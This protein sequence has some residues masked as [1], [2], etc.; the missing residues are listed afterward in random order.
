MKMLPQ[1]VHK[2]HQ[3][4]VENDKVIVIEKALANHKSR[5]KLLQYQSI[6]L[7]SKHKK[8]LG[9]INSRKKSMKF[10]SGKGCS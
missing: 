2:V 9:K 4:F 3:C 5:I 1:C 10:L 6:G 8:G 7:E